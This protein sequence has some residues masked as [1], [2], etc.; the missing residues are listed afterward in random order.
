M[1]H[2]MTIFNHYP[3]ITGVL[4]FSDPV[5]LAGLLAAGIPVLLH[6]LNRVRSPIVP[7][8]TLR[9]LRITAQKTSRKRQIQQFL[10]LLLRMAV[11]ALIAMAI[12]GP[13]VHGGT[14]QLAYGMVVLM[15]AGLVGAAAAV[16]AL[17]N[18]W[19]RPH[20]PT[21]PVTA[22]GSVPGS[23]AA[24]ASGN[25]VRRRPWA[26]L[27]LLLAALAA[28]AA[29]VAGLTSNKFFPS[30]A[31]HFNGAN[32]AVVII[33]DNSQSMLAVEGGQ[34]RLE[35][36]VRLTRQLIL[37][38]LHPARQAVLLTN[39]GSAPIPDALSANRI[40]AVGRLENISSQGRALPMTLLVARAAKL[41]NA[42]HLPEKVLIIISDFAGP[43]ASETNMF[44]GL[45]PTPG[46]QL[47][48]MPQGEHN[49]PDDVA[50]ESFRVIRGQAVVGSPI[51]CKAKLV[52][53]GTTAVVP[54]VDLAMEGTPLPESMAK[55]TLGPAGTSQA[56]RAVKLRC[57]LKAPGWQL[58]EAEINNPT[59]VLP[60]AD[61]RRLILKTASK[62]KA[63]VVGN[64]SHPL[65]GSAAFYAAA[66]LAPYANSQ[67][68]PG[69][70][71]PWS[72][73]SRTIGYRRLPTT[74]L[75]PFGAI[76]LCDVP[77]LTHADAQRLQAFAKSG[78]RI[79]WLLGPSVN[80][81]IYNS[82]IYKGF[83]LLPGELRRIVSSTRGQKV[84]TV[85]ARSYLCGRLFNSNR[86][87]RRIVVADMWT[88]G[89]PNSATKTVM[90]V[91][92]GRP[93]LFDQIVGKG[94]IYTFTSSPAGGW[95]NIG[96]TSVFL[97]L[98]VRIA[99]GNAAAAARIASFEAGDRISLPLPQSVAPMSVNVIL[100]KSHA[101]INIKPKQGPSGHWRWGFRQ[102][103]QSG[104]YQWTTFNGKKSGRFVI[105]PPGDEADLHPTPAAI[106]AKMVKLKHP[107]LIASTAAKLL[108][109]I[110][111]TN[112]G[113]S[114]MPG[115][116]ALVAI[117]AVLEV[118]VSNRRPPAK[119]MIPAPTQSGGGGS[120][121]LPERQAA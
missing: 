94:R 118:L 103:D 29:S 58:I 95:S 54:G 3:L 73:R 108:S 76:F 100:P 38:T 2:M 99:L 102:T 72:I 113:S 12:A 59:G 120:P 105:N 9:F 42:S 68:S 36:A 4:T 21:A 66:A 47:V 27:G 16:A 101:T 83:G 57:T 89:L 14:P 18:Q 69:A 77:A 13:L 96:A 92:S 51:T 64:S 114:L 43:A 41:L 6:M 81:K 65:P 119:T 23:T 53:N 55:V 33:L 93:L 22:S 50:I 106:L 104:I 91:Q 110:K 115:I 24:A 8:S 109:V 80:R 67:V 26:V 111:K 46:I 19:E 84:S 30:S 85:D 86:P 35:R 75:H 60:W 11:F 44:A 52:N 70:S 74:G 25:V 37:R 121:A 98:V 28:F 5:L 17:V 79:C 45:K 39:P 20:P 117:L 32:S 1:T 15:L 82:A 71:P 62:I 63:L 116:L 56:V 10:L 112:S 88:L 48:L 61:H 49:A 87:F 34:T 40:N 78:G 90:A 97:P 7:F 107:V 31:V